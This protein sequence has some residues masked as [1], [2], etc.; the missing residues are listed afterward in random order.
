MLFTVK[1]AVFDIFSELTGKIDNEIVDDIAHAVVAIDRY[2][3]Q[4]IAN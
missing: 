2:A 3:D 1:R 4:R